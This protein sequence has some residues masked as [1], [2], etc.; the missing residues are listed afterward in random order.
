MITN[1]NLIEEI[2][3]LKSIENHIVSQE[4]I[5]QAHLKRAQNL[6]FQI[7]LKIIKANTIKLDNDKMYKRNDLVLVPSNAKS[8]N[9]NVISKNYTF[10]SDDNCLSNLFFSL[11]LY[12]LQF[13]N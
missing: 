7:K 3:P 9:E 2:N 8:L 1:K 12:F 5:Y 6:H 11:I 4:L 13:F 10:I